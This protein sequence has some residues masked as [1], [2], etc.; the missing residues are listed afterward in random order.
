MKRTLAVSFALY[1][2][3]FLVPL[4]AGGK[5][6]APVET[7]AETTPSPAAVPFAE[8]PAPSSPPVSPSPSPAPP[9]GYTI[10]V[11]V[12]GTPEEISLR[13]FLLGAVAAEMP[14]LYPEEALKA[15]TVAIRTFALYAQS[16]PYHE[17]A[18]LCADWECCLAFSPLEGREA[19][20]GEQYEEYARKIEAAV[21]E[22]AGVV[23]LYEGEPIEAVFFAATDGRTRSAAEVWGGEVPYLQSVG[24]D[25]DLEFAN[26]PRGHGVGMSQ[27]GAR[28]LALRGL[29]YE[30]I[31]KWYYTGVE[32]TGA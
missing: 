6:P 11:L 8:K 3:V 12:E 17:N 28:Q 22:T 24:S 14:A 31:L 20:W 16:R 19:D 21:D 25:F 5:L 15:Q 30:E 9:P 1:L 10:T 18:R 7:A 32:I 27:F 4:L 2:A 26:G 13:G 23:I 29:G